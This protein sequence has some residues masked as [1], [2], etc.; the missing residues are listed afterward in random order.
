MSVYGAF[1]DGM[2]DTAVDTTSDRCARLFP[3]SARHPLPDVGTAIITI[4]TLE[5]AQ[6]AA[7]RVA[8]TAKTM[9]KTLSRA[10]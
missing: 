1:F 7:E 3:F 2:H 8:S 9:M 5:S 6:V 10:A 4:V